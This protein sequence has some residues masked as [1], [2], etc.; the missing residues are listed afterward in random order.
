MCRRLAASLAQ[1]E[2]ECEALRVGTV[3]GMHQHI[4]QL[5]EE[6]AQRS[7]QL[8]DLQGSHADL[9]HQMA[10]ATAQLEQAG[11]ERRVL[12]AV[13]EGKVRQSSSAA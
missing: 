10:A 3:G 8:A 2:A 13:Y 11:V 1:Q 7:A 4:S 12:Q 9:Q 5:S 6:L